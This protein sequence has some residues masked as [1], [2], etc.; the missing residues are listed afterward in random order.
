MSKFN[1][2]F[3]SFTHVDTFLHSINPIVT[4]KLYMDYFIHFKLKYIML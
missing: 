4:Q 3:C 1:L 2:I